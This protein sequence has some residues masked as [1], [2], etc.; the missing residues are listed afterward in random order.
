MNSNDN[1]M[2]NDINVYETMNGGPESPDTIADH[3]GTLR[4]LGIDYDEI[5]KHVVE[6][7]QKV[8]NVEINNKIVCTLGTNEKMVAILDMIRLKWCD[9]DNDNDIDNNIKDTRN[10]QIHNILE[11]WKTLIRYL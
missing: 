8:V 9:N 2:I 11:E 10:N 4:D 1:K 3:V 6:T 7:S 5:S